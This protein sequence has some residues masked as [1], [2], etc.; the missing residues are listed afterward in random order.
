MDYRALAERALD[1]RAEVFEK[2]KA[3]FDDPKYK[4]KSDALRAKS[5]AYD[6]QMD[7]LAAEAR[8]YVEEG[9]RDQEIRGAMKRS[10]ALG[11]AANR[12]GNGPADGEWR[13]LLP[14]HAEIREMHETRAES[15]TEYLIP[16]GTAAKY[17]DML[18][19]K[20]VFLK[21]IPREN[22][23]QFDDRK[24]TMPVLSDSDMPALVQENALI[25]EGDDAWAGLEFNSKAYKSYRTC[26][27]ETLADSGLSLRNAL[28]DTMLRNLAVEFD[29]DAFAGTGGTNT[30]LLGLVGQGVS[31]PAAATGTA[32]FNDI[33][34]AIE[35]LWTANAEP[36]VIW[37]AP[38][39]AGA[40]SREREG[41]DGA[42][43]ADS[44]SAV[45]LARRLPQL[46]STNVPAGTVVVADGSRVHA[47]IRERARV[48]VSEHAEFQNDK[49]A[50]RLTQRCAGVYAVESSSVQVIAENSA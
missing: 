41:T 31:T 39:A 47:G 13:G 21:G 37:L 6:E 18:R 4:G 2:R 50:L 27:N 29:A 1:K 23:H 48:A 49:T 36:T 11:E 7:M 30:P 40:L 16:E 43:L 24:W 9:Q 15:G 46:V 44:D 28:A 12:G 20:A 26:G 42:Y 34:L 8:Q 22:L 17:I 32:T 3:L 19:A 5:E 14:S 45:G 10:G 35:R 33:S 38:D 25:V